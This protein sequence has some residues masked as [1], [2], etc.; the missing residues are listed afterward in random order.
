MSAANTCPQEPPETAQCIGTT[1]GAPRA[2]LSWR[3]P[4]AAA[5]ASL[6][7]A[8][9]LS[10]LELVSVMIAG[11]PGDAGDHPLAASIVSRVLVG[12]LYLSVA[13]RLQWARWL[14][15]LLGFASVALVGPTLAL[16]WQ[17]FPAGAMVSGMALA[18]RLSASV[19]LMAPATRRTRHASGE[20]IE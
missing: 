18:C 14:T 19:C 15:V 8:Y 2:W 10:W 5:M 9:V 6:A 13:W 17:V 20:G 4:F 1:G 7:A 12:M 16:Q 3:G 11:M